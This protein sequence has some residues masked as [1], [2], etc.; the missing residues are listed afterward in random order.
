MVQ[1]I[2]FQSLGGL[3]AGRAWTAVAVACACLVSLGCHTPRSAVSGAPVIVSELLF[4][5]SDAQGSAEFIE[6]ANIAGEP[7]DLSGWQIT[8]A[9]RIGIPQGMKV[10]PG[11]TVVLCKHEETCAKIGGRPLKHA[12][13]LEGKLKNKGE[14]V[15]IEDPEGRVA[16]EATYDAADPSI[17]G[18]CGTGNS[19]HRANYKASEGKGLWHVGPPTPGHFELK[20]IA[21][22]PASS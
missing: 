19:I 3:G 8:G 5:P 11:E 6:I 13:A 12:V 21:G 4:Y 14:T 20:S 1:S 15:R 7:I 16:D 18:A 9:G 2:R 10:G 22:L 17:Q